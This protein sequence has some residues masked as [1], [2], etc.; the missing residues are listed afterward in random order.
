VF[1]GR[2]KRLLNQQQ[3]ATLSKQKCA[4]CLQDRQYNVVANLDKASAWRAN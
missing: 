3:D 2:E 1:L 4:K